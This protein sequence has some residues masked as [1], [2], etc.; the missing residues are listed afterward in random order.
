MSTQDYIKNT[1]IRLLCA[2]VLLVQSDVLTVDYSYLKIPTTAIEL[3][4]AEPDDAIQNLDTDDYYRQASRA[5]LGSEVFALHML[6]CLPDIFYTPQ[7]NKENIF[8]D[9]IDFKFG[10][11]SFHTAFCVFRI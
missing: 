3:I 2:I 9:N 11:E 6:A 1:V 7:Y 4:Q 5:G 8:V 10:Y